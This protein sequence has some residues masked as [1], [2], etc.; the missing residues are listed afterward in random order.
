MKQV[1]ALF[2]AVP[3]RR[4]RRQSNGA[5][6]FMCVVV[7]VSSNDELTIIPAR[8]RL[9]YSR[10]IT[11]VIATPN[12]K[13]PVTEPGSAKGGGLFLSSPA[14]AM[15]MDRLLSTVEVDVEHGLPTAEV[16]NRPRKFGANQLS[17][18]PPV[19]SWRK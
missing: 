2:G 10:T 19:P 8:R 9:L 5:T 4:N 3:Q 18:A 13:K 15:E 1:V 17:E 6:K 11:H 16:E 7:V 14:Y 12:E